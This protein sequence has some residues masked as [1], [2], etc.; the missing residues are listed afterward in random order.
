[1]ARQFAD[2][3]P[4]EVLAL[5][6]NVEKRNAERMTTFAQMFMQYDPRV[7]EVFEELAAEE[8][9]H[10]RLLEAR[11]RERYG[12]QM[13]PVAEEDVLEVVEA[14]DLEHGET[15][16]FDDHTVRAAL[17]VCLRAE[18]NAQ[19]FYQE[20]IPRAPDEALRAVYVELANFEDDHIAALNT[21]LQA[22]GKG[23]GRGP[24]RS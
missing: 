1:M 19:L 14:I 2:L 8:V 9:Q 11:Y 6:V 7:G 18:Q 4:Q 5:A 24:E 17:E 10:Q 13:L 12:D 23:T 21:R 20:M 22:L 3:N 15:Y 16:V